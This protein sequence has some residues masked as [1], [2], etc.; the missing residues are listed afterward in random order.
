VAWGYVDHPPLCVV[1][2]WAWRHTFSQSML[3]I[4]ALAALSGAGTVLVT[5]LIVR[6][7]GG[8]TWGSRRASS[9]TVR[10]GTTEG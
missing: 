2:V 6:A 7:L 8:G 5:G 1:A 3:A 9:T 10:S 4:R